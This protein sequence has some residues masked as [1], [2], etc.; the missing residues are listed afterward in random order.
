MARVVKRIHIPRNEFL[1]FCLVQAG[2]RRYCTAGDVTGFAVTTDARDD[3][4]VLLVSDKLP[5]DDEIRA[6]SDE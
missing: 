5:A 1:Q 3:L 4:S 6:T 2:L